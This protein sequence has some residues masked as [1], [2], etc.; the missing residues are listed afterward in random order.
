MIFVTHGVVENLDPERISHGLM[1]Q[2]SAF[3]THL[4]ERQSKYVTVERSVAG[5]GDALTV[6]DATLAGLDQ[7]LLTKSLGHAV[8][9]FVNGENVEA[10]LTYFPFLL[11]WMIDE[12]TE[13]DCLFEG[14]R[15]SLRS[16]QDRKTFRLHLKAVYMRCTHWYEIADLTEELS[17]RLHVHGDLDEL[18]LKTAS[19]HDL[20]RAAHCGVI[21]GNHGWSHF[22]PLALSPSRR[23]EEIMRNRVWL[24]QFQACQDCY[25]PAFG[26]RVPLLEEFCPLMLLAESSATTHTRP[27]GQV[28]RETLRLASNVPATANERFGNQLLSEMTA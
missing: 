2:R 9:W 16:I 14:K 4:Q 7:V 26:S 15:W 27:R 12:A 21:L 18:F 23:R 8:T 20:E 3:I 10:D 22:N 1:L 25:A 11:S 19:H 13:C 28:N 5:F 6:D 24:R 17:R